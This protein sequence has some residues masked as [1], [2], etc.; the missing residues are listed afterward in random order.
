MIEL[1]VKALNGAPAVV[2]QATPNDSVADV[3]RR[4]AAADPRYRGCKLFYNVSWWTG[5]VTGS[6]HLSLP[7]PFPAH[8]A[9]SH[10][11]YSV[12]QPDFHRII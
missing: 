3:K 12:P 4:L 9:A 11:G 6:A 2:L 5:C 10:D 8:V 7:A 1:R